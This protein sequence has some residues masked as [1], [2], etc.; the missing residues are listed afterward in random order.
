MHPGSITRAKAFPPGATASQPGN[1]W[2]R[3]S[4]GWWPIVRE[5]FTGA[6][7]QHGAPPGKRLDYSAV[8]ACVTL[9]ASDIA[10]IGLK[11]QEDGDG[12]FTESI[13]RRFRRC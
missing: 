13:A 1:S 12:I 6:W 9:T 11:R 7:H 8:Y 4:G 10:K 2:L 5:P 3:G